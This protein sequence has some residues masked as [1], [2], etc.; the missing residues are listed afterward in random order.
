MKLLFCGTRVV[1]QD[2]SCAPVSTGA[3]RS[4]A[5]CPAQAESLPQH[6]SATAGGRTESFANG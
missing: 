1:G 4:G 3:F 6:V 5:K 2:L